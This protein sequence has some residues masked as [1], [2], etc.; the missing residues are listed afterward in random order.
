MAAVDG[1][2]LVDARER[3]AVGR[4]VAGHRGVAFLTGK[5]R[6]RVMP[7]PIVEIAVSD[8]FDHV[9]AQADV[10]DLDLADRLA[11]GRRR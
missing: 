10:G 8:A 3:R 5:R 7:G 6:S 9:G 11:L 2:E 4:A 1:V